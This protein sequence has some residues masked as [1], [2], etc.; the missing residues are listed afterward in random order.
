[1][2]NLLSVYVDVQCRIILKAEVMLAVIICI[3]EAN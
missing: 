1:M 2:I 3:I